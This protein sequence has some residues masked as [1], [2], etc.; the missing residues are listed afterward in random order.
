VDQAATKVKVELFGK[1]GS[2]WRPEAGALGSVKGKQNQ[3]GHD[4]DFDEQWQLLETWSFHLS[5]LIPFSG[6]VCTFA[7][8]THS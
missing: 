6:P 3:K 1:L 8:P 7:F 2:K 5:D 4:S